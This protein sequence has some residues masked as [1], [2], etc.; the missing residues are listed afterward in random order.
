M[1]EKNKYSV[2]EGEKGKKTGNEIRNVNTR[3]KNDG[4]KKREK[5]KDKFR[6]DKGGKSQRCIICSRHEESLRLMPRPLLQF[7][8]HSVCLFFSFLFF[9]GIHRYKTL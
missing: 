8:Y 9:S 5:S 1:N 7:I 3:K 6:V 4:K 2:R